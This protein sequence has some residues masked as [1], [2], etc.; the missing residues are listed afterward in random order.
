MSASVMVCSR[1][2]VRLFGVLIKGCCEEVLTARAFSNVW[3]PK[4]TAALTL[5]RVFR[6]ITVY[7]KDER[8][9]RV[10]VCSPRDSVRSCWSM[11]GN[12]LRSLVSRLQGGELKANRAV[13][14]RQRH[15]EQ[16]AFGPK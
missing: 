2:A 15:S 6:V 13:G 7:K 12:L 3:L 16:P 5:R 8:G 4:L 1:D 10:E 14:T 11:F 9:K